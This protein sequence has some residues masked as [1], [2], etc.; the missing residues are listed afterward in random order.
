MLIIPAIDL[1]QGKCVRLSQGKMDESTVYSDSPAETA[2]R[3]QAEGAKRL[4]IVD[5]DGAV[6]GIPKNMDAV[7]QIRAAVNMELELGGG[8]RDLKTVDTYFSAGIDYIIL[9]TAAIRDPELLRQSCEKYPG[10]II[11]GIDARDGQVSVQGWTEDTRT[12]A[13]DFARTLD[14]EKVSAIVF[15]D[16]SRDGMLTGPNI[17]STAALARAVDIPV[18]ASGGISGMKDITALMKVEDSGIFA[19]IVGRA[20]YTG[21]INLAQCIKTA[22]KDTSC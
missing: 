10:R 13:I 17:Q 6:S 15:T 7:K 19:A 18:V 3:W 11:I 22:G 14:P 16:I 21:N 8:I 9:G 12:S 2:A 4:H 5:L 20:L 1:K